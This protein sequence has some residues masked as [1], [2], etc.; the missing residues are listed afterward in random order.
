MQEIAN[1]VGIQYEHLRIK[2]LFFF[3]GIDTDW[4]RI[5]DSLAWT[6]EFKNSAYQK[7]A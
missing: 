3:N 1:Q 4:G 5:L 6:N 7:F 2:Y